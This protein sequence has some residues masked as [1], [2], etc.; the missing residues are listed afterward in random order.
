M[1][2]Q[3]SQLIRGVLQRQATSQEEG[4]RHAPRELAA[5]RTSTQL[6]AAAKRWRPGRIEREVSHFDA[7]AD[8]WT[9]LATVEIQSGWLQTG[10]A[11]LPWKEAVTKHAQDNFPLSGEAL[12]QDGSSLHLRQRSNGWTLAR[13]TEHKAQTE[14]QLLQ[15]VSYRI[16]SKVG[17]NLAGDPMRSL[18]AE[19]IVYQIAYRQEEGPDP[20][21]PGQLRAYASR[22]KAMDPTQ[23]QQS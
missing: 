7:L 16:R 14:D 23:E 6:H 18:G 4:L 15:E 22:I 20:D 17:A 10:W 13:Y 11:L 21:S 8:I 1:T 2:N 9:Q 3:L 12:C 19:T 5:R